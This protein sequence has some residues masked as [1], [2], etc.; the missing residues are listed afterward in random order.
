MKKVKLKSELVQKNLNIGDSIKKRDNSGVKVSSYSFSK[1]HLI[2]CL[3]SVILV[4]TSLPLNAVS[5]SVVSQAKVTAEIKL[6]ANKF[7]AVNQTG[8]INFSKDE[9]VY[10]M[11]SLDGSFDGNVTIVN[12]IHPLDNI[13]DGELYDFGIYDNLSPL[14]FDAKYSISDG[15]EILWEFEDIDNLPEGFFYRG[16]KSETMLPFGFEIKYYFNDEIADPGTLAGKSGE[17]K[18]EISVTPNNNVNR[19]YLEN[20]AAQIQIPFNSQNFSAINAPGS[21]QILTGETRTVNLTVL[22]GKSQTFTLEAKV[23][24]F[25]MDEI[26][27]AIT[28]F[29]S[30]IIKQVIPADTKD[31]LDELSKGVQQ[32]AGGGVQLNIGIAEFSSAIGG[33]RGGY[34]ELAQGQQG[35][36][37]GIEE[38]L[39]GVENIAEGH[40]ALS[41]GLEELS[42][43]GVGL[44]EAYEDLGNEVSALLDSLLPVIETLPE[45]ERLP[46]IER[47]T[48]IKE[49]LN[50]YDHHLNQYIDV[51]A[52]I[53]LS[54]KELSDGLVEIS[55]KNENIQ[56]GMSGLVMGSENFAGGLVVFENKSSEL[57]QGSATL[58]G[59]LSL[60]SKE[61]SSA[62]LIFQDLIPEDDDSNP[63]SFADNKT[64]VNSVNFIVSIPSIKM[65]API[66][67]E[68]AEV[69]VKTFW[70][71]F[72]DLFRKSE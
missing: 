72:L 59:S 14:S 10:A 39:S 21:A 19:Y 50:I 48:I 4:T 32:I 20:F 64:G 60:L 2:I 56:S 16:E 29:S 65:S 69:P 35:L 54:S 42:F 17:L 40:A 38:Y 27:I 37:S 58:S 46:F 33:I 68:P 11:L 49:Q 18:L 23:S 52:N 28:P 70:E 55:G 36:F 25:E 6:E 63:L 1:K 8:S 51:I 53:S 57:T 13:P 30:D 26:R 7:T 41:S 62:S 3:L 12:F 44:T 61:L 71:R 67:S 22:P 31:K 66:E 24:N 5:E 34:N 47:I 45:E 15:G 9:T 43:G